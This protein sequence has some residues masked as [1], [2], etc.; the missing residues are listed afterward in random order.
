M[1]IEHVAFMNIYVFTYIC[2]RV[3]VCIQEQLVKKE[4]TNLKK[5]EKGYMGVY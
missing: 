5:S 4:A 2:V 1:H 3:C